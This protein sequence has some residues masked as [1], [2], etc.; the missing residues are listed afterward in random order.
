M[1]EE[2]TAL[3]AAC[4]ALPSA[5]AARAAEPSLA[6]SHPFALGVLQQAEERQRA[7]LKA[8]RESAAGEVRTARQTMEAE[9]AAALKRA[10]A[11]REEAE[12]A[13]RVQ[14]ERL[15]V[16]TPPASRCHHQHRHRH[17]IISG[18]TIGPTGASLPRLLPRRRTRASSSCCA[19]R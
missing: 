1:E 3:A 16:P 10:Q 18:A 9:K 8:L 4:R 6:P 12:E 11:E 5:L 17:H 19:R 14:L 13:L 15:Q 2:G 7:E